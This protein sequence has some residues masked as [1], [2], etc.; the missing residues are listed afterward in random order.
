[1]FHRDNLQSIISA[2]YMYIDIYNIEYPYQLHIYIIC[3]IGFG[4]RFG[5]IF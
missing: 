4:F 3:Y 5:S 1:M 2:T